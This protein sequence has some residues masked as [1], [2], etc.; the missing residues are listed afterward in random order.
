MV[1]L[2]FD[3]TIVF[4]GSKKSMISDDVK[5]TKNTQLRRNFT[6][7]SQYMMWMNDDICFVDFFGTST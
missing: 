6:Y 3:V 7:P 5:Q 1:L 2:R 4:G